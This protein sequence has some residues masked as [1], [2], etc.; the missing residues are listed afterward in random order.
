[1]LSAFHAPMRFRLTRMVTTR[2]LRSR[3]YLPSFTMLLPSMKPLTVS[4]M[5]WIPTITTHRTMSPTR[6]P[7]C[8]RRACLWFHL[9]RGYLFPIRRGWHWRIQGMHSQWNHNNRRTEARPYLSHYRNCR[10][11]CVRRHA[12]FILSSPREERPIFLPREVP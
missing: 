5:V 1:M 7:G 8:Q 3:K 10:T 4:T 11:W 9:L 12:C 6:Q 2:P